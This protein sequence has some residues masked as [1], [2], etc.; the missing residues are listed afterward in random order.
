MPENSNKLLRSINGGKI[1]YPILI[2]LSVAAVMLYQEFKVKELP[3]VHYTWQL[4]FW[5]AIA[6]SMMALR[7]F[8]YMLR[9]RILTK[10]KLSW[11]QS[12]KIIMM[13]E[14]TSAVTPSMIGGTSIAVI[15]FHREGISIG[16]S[17]AIVMATSFLDQLY[18]SVFFPI[19]FLIVGPETLFTIGT[20]ITDTTNILSFNNLFFYFAV[21]GYSLMLGYTLLVAYG[22][23]I[24]PR[25]LKVL[26][27]W[28]FKL[29]FFRRWNRKAIAAGSDLVTASYE[30]KKNGFLFWTKAFGATIFAWSG[31]YLIVNFLLLA[32]A[33]QG[34]QFLIYTRQFVMWIMMIVSPTPGGAGFAEYVFSQYLNEFI[35]NGFTSILAFLWRV[36]S[37]YPYLFI[38]AII[39]P[40]WLKHKFTLPKKRKLTVASSI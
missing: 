15:F 13:W 12:F 35:P 7:D 38:G 28:I 40:R 11:R 21:V 3:T 34:D 36:I 6:F 27:Y 32:F 22:L 16:R 4:F 39:V 23:F 19:L 10:K 18:F 26:L 9:V 31:R 14:F 37:Y 29:P 30:L 33:T 2:G 17:S 20:Q 25:G 8:G 5:I 24:N 1:V